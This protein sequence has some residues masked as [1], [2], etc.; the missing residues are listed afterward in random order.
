[1]V[2]EI[3]MLDVK[4]GQDREFE[5]ALAQAAPLL[6]GMPGFLGYDL[7]R[8]VEDP[9][10]YALLVRWRTL[11]DHTRGFRGSPQHQE[12]RRLLSHF[13][14]GAPVVAHFRPITSGAPA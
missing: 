6:S 5:A 4:D 3:A 14:S 1:M 9:N 10:R 13:Y 2:L 11:E 7:H 8:G 12:W